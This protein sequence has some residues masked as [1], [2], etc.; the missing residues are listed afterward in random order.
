MGVQFRFRAN[1]QGL[2]L[3]PFFLELLRSRAQRVSNNSG[4]LPLVHASLPPIPPLCR[5]NWAAPLE[6]RPPAMGSSPIGS[7]RAAPRM[8]ARL[9]SKEGRA[10]MLRAGLL[11]L[12]LGNS[13]HSSAQTTSREPLY[14]WVGRMGSSTDVP[15]PSTG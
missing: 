14:K 11:L 6:P 10:A 2:F 3:S 4:K 8:T 13:T 1:I 7:K 5:A 9:P 15:G 12:P